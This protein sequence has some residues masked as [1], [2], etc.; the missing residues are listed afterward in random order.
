MS[1]DTQ[2]WHIPDLIDL[3][4]LVEQDEGEDLD[5]LAARDRELFARMQVDTAKNPPASSLL[6]GWLQAR[7]RALEASGTE[8]LPGRIWHELFVLFTWG[9]LAGG[10]LAGGGLAFS[11]LSYGG[12]RPVNVSAYFGIFVV[13]EALLFV[14]LLAASAYRHLLGRQLNGFFLFRLVR[15]LFFAA[16]ERIARKAAGRASADSRMQWSARSSMF[17]RLQQRYGALFSRPF[18]LLAQLLGV[19]FNAGILGATLLKVIGSDVAFGWQTTLQVGSETVHTLV[20]WI[21]LPWSW[22]GQGCCPGP[23]Q[24]E[25]SRLILKDG[26]YH[27]ATPDLVSWWPFLCLAVLVYGL[28]PRLGLLLFTIYRQRRDLAG[29]SFDHGRYRQLVHRMQTPVLSTRARAEAAADGPAEEAGTRPSA[30]QQAPAAAP[31]PDPEQNAGHREEV[32]PL[33]AAL[34]GLV[35]EEIFADVS[36]EELAVAVEER[37]GYRLEG[38]VP[39]FTLDLDEAEEL[40]RIRQGMEDKQCTD[41]LLLQEAWQPPIQELLSFLGSLRGLLGET[42]IIIIALVGK[43]SATTLLT[44]VAPLNLQVWQQKIA[45]LGDPGVQMIQLVK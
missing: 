45:T 27:L 5:V 3:E 36:Q 10:L 21:S 19:A 12:S 2:R 6:R 30:R 20:R 26:I 35:P 29:L 37:L 34:L 11:F 44:P 23:A 4:Y 33:Q 14:V 42:P 32:A 31:S 18:F 16:L 24:I 13:F 9:C 8:V 41:L 39:V 15:R 7:R 17:R 43:P 22:I 40:Q 38:L 1:M 25:G 28:L